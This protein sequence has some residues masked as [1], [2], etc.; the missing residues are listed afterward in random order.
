MLSLAFTGL[1]ATGS[2][3]ANLTP[4]EQI[5]CPSLR[6][7]LDIVKRHSASEFDYAVLE[8]EFQRFGPTGRK[9]LMDILDSE[10]GNPDIAEIISRAAPLSASERL[11]LKK[12]WS[13]DRAEIYLPFLRDG[14]PVSRDLLLL[15]LG[16]DNPNVRE[17]ARLALI[18]LPDPIK[19]QPVPQSLV[20]PVLLA[21]AKDPII[22]A[23]PYL[24]R[25]NAQGQE[26]GFAELLK[27]GEVDVVFGAYEALYR[28]NRPKAFETLLSVMDRLKAPDQSQAIGD[29][30]LRRHANRA[31]GFYLNFAKEMSGDQARS[32]SARASALHAVLL[33]NTREM[34]ELTPARAEALRFLASGQPLVTAE[35][36]I[37]FLKR[38]KAEKELNL[39]WRVATA[40][41]WVNRDVISVAFVGLQSEDQIIRD[42]I[43]SDDFRSFSAGAAKAKPRHKMLLNSKI[44]HPVKD[45]QDLARKILDLPTA[46]QSSAR[47]IISKF[48]ANDQLNQMPFFDLAW[49]KLKSNARVALDRKYLTSAHPSQTGWLAGYELQDSSAKSTPRDSTLLHFNNKTGGFKRIG[50]FSGPVAILPDRSLKL[51]QSTNRFW[52]INQSQEASADVSAYSVDL[53]TEVPRVKHLGALPKNVRD[54][55]VAPNGDLLLGF[56]GRKQA[57]LRMSQRGE[58]SAAC[59]S[60]QAVTAASAP[61]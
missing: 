27:S 47:C 41:K 13:L 9:A 1:S 35:K 49:V 30:I 25:L 39:I 46:S 38:L 5:V 8:S 50:N 33:S 34:P 52:V 36:Y 55:S 16:S 28:S 18:D 60:L 31:D 22:E 7:C 53:T 21:L 19:R 59:R 40:E 48:D 51:G 12:K 17:Q 61:N 23:A 43:R 20:Q 44:N 3:A 11:D 37:P 10:A 56:D 29:M 58:I 6:V 45:I 15:S 57:P 54:F 42:L 24:S 14:H 2:E 26:K 4:K 32:V